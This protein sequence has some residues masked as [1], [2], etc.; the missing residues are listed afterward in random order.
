MSDEAAKRGN[1]TL[2]LDGELTIRRARQIK[3]ILLAQLQ[4][5]KA[6]DLDL[7]D[8]SAIDISGLQL[9]C[10]AHRTLKKSGG[11]LRVA[12]QL[13]ASIAQIVRT[14]GF[15]R[16]RDCRPNCDHPCLWNLGE[17]I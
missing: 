9:L 13:P 10:S 8:V 4:A 3:D 17:P 12:S 2:V 1:I 14:A 16:R 5:G 6:T 7:T 11:D 15:A